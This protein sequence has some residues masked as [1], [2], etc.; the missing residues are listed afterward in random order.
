VYFE[1]NDVRFSSGVVNTDGNNPW[2]VPY[3]GA[4]VVIRS[5]LA[6]KQEKP[7]KPVPTRKRERVASGEPASDATSAEKQGNLNAAEVIHY[8][9]SFHQ[10]G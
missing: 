10:F 3:S 7:T 1:D 5:C 4:R 8:S 9:W 6:M 2:I